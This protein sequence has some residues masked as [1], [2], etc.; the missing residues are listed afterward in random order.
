MCHS[1][2]TD[3]GQLQSA[4]SVCAD[5]DRS[6]SLANEEGRSEERGVHRTMQRCHSG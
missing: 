5:L 6:L 3:G 4:E 1:T 2:A